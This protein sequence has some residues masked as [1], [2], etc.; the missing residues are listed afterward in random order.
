[1]VESQVERVLRL[2]DAY[3]SALVLQVLDGEQQLNAMELEL[4]E[5]ISNVIARRQPAAR[6]LRLLMAASK[7]VTNL[8][9]AGDE[10]RKVAKRLRRVHGNDETQTINTTE[11]RRSGELA[12]MIL[13][14]ALDAFARMDAVAAAQIVRDDEA[15]DNSFRAFGR[16]LVMQMTEAPRTIPVDLEYMFIG[17]AIER[18][19][20]HATN[21]A[22]FVVYVVMGRDVRHVPLD[23]LDEEVLA[24]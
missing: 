3:D 11:L 24:N 16:R 12:L 13:R 20:D 1:M 6:D 23:R 21:I 5:E 22:E 15:V 14:R 2:M 18:I 7:C 17:K 8:E 9:R 4:D 10:A 19:G